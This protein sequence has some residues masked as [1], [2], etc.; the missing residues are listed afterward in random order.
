MQSCIYL[1]PHVALPRRIER[2]S[3]DY[4]TTNHLHLWQTRTHNILLVDSSHITCMDASDNII[5]NF[6]P[7]S[8]HLDGTEFFVPSNSW[9]I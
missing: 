4:T 3:Y 8:L 5:P 9:M 1:F 6:L 2:D 7:W